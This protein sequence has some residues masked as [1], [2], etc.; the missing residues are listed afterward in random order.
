MKEG[1]LT[2]LESARGFRSIP[3]SPSLI[4]SGMKK[5]IDCMGKKP[6]VTGDYDDAEDEEGVAAKKSFTKSSFKTNV[7]A[8]RVLELCYPKVKITCSLQS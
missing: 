8:M 3:S 6:L 2:R 5:R 1:K 7:K 4:F